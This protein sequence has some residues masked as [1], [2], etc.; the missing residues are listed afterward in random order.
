MAAPQDLDRRLAALTLLFGQVATRQSRRGY[1]AAV[2]FPPSRDPLSA[3]DAIQTL[4][5]LAKPLWIQV[6]AGASEL[7]LDLAPLPDP[8][9]L[10]PE[11]QRHY[12]FLSAEDPLAFLAKRYIP[13]LDDLPLACGAAGEVIV[14]TVAEFR[15]WRRQ[16]FIEGPYDLGCDFADSH[17]PLAQGYTREQLG[18]AV[19]FLSYCDVGWAFLIL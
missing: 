8:D 14:L 4:C 12:R 10:S 6:G 18:N 5:Q 3:A 15:E 2:R 11:A 7:V 13:P 17:Y 19:G 16:Y 1:P 9:S